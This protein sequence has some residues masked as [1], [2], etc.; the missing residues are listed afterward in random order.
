METILFD[1]N[2]MKSKKKL[3]FIK[4]VFEYYFIII[5]WSER[6]A[7]LRTLKMNLSIIKF[8]NNTIL[9]VTILINAFTFLMF[10]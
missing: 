9:H 10:M 3:S 8:N 1:A 5:L 6:V 2:S 4:I 7:Y